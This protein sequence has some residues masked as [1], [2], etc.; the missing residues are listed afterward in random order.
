MRIPALVAVAVFLTFPAWAGE[1]GMDSSAVLVRLAMD[2][3]IAVIPHHGTYSLDSQIKILDPRFQ[4]FQALGD[5]PGSMSAVLGTYTV[6]R[7]TGEVW[8]D[9]TCTRVHFP[10]LRR[11]Q[12]RYRA[13]FHL[14]SPHAL[15]SPLC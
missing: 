3:Q 9:D 2:H 12:A 10:A 14:A 1:L 7:L 5:W 4:T 11:M 15:L 6:N 8:N 13:R